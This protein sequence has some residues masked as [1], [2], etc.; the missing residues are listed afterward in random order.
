MNKWIEVLKSSTI[1]KGDNKIVKENLQRNNKILIKKQIKRELLTRWIQKMA[2][3]SLNLV[4]IL[5]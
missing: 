4:K 3:S 1:T 2:S 5:Q